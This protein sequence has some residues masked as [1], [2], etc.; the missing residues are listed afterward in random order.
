MGDVQ[1]AEEMRAYKENTSKLISHVGFQEPMAPE[2]FLYQVV[3]Q[4]RMIRMMGLL[5]LE[6]QRKRLV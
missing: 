1:E 4:K 6:R 3:K 2:K 5:Q